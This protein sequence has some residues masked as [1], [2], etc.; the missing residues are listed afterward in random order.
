MS[1]F[2][3]RRSLLVCRNHD[4]IQL[5][6]VVELGRFRFR[7]TGHARQL[8]EHAEIIL[9]GNRRQRLVLA[10]DLHAFLGFNRLMQAVGPAPP[11][12]HAPGKF[13]DDDD[14]PVFDDVFHV[15]AIQRVRLDRRLDVMFQ[16][17]VLRVGNVSN[18]EQSLDL[19][20]AFIGHRDVAVLFIDHE[21]AGKLRGFTR[22]DLRSLR[23]SPAWE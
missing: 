11:R 19:H 18:A 3:I 23:P 13:V 4:H 20:P 6:D 15:L 7:R 21:V 14:F 2:S 8:L 10:L 5:I 12:H 16:V 9:E 22:G 1:G 17:P